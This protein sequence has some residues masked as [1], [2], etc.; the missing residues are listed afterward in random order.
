MDSLKSLDSTVTDSN[1]KAIESAMRILALLYIRDPTIDL[2]CGEILFLDLLN[3]RKQA[4][5]SEDSLIDPLLLRSHIAQKPTLIWMCIAGNCF[6]TLEMKATGEYGA[7]NI[8]RSTIY[9]ELLNE[10]LGPEVFKK[11]PELVSEDMELSRCLDLKYLRGP[12]WNSRT[13]M[14]QILGVIKRE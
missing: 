5:H 2:P 8:G 13:A 1:I 7:N 12:H 9:K 11:K 6:T 10:V 4:R 3:Q 14:R